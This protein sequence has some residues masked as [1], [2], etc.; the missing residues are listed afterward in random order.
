MCLVGEDI[1]PEGV[2]AHLQELCGE[3]NQDRD[4]A[5]A[6][7]THSGAAKNYF[8][9]DQAKILLPP[10]PADEVFAYRFAKMFGEEGVDSEHG[11]VLGAELA[12]WGNRLPDQIGLAGA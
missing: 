12:G 3:A 2:L 8:S 11:I 10:L 4:M 9:R 1:H 7:N 5:E 6:L